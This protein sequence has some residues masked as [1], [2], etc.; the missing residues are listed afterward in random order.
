MDGQA[1]HHV[2]ALRFAAPH[3]PRGLPHTP[4]HCCR[5]LLD[6]EGCQSGHARAAL[7]YCLL[8]F[9][10]LPPAER[11]N[12]RNLLDHYVFGD[13]EAVTHIPEGR[14]GVLGALTPE[15]VE[16]LKQGARQHL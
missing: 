2:P 12:W 6:V 16:Q 13:E 4:A 7:Y 10:A 14:R 5:N 9:R 8:A 1:R 3:R 11:A 15:T